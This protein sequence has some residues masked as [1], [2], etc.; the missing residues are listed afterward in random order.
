MSK[1][2]STMQAVI[3]TGHGGPEMLEVKQ[4]WSV[5][6]PAADEV[7]IKVGAAG[8]NNTDI[9]TRIGWYSKSVTADTDAAASS[10]G[11]IEVDTSDSSWAGASIQFPRIQGADVCG[12]IVAVGTGVSSNRIGERVL[13][14]AM[15]PQPDSKAGLNC[16][17]LGSEMDGGFAEY[18]TV[19]SDMT[20]SIMSSD[21]T[22]AELASFPCAAS[23]AENMLDRIG[24]KAGETVLITGASGGVGSA[25]VQLAKL[26]G[27]MVTA[28]AATEKHDFVRSLGA[29]YL[30]DRGDTLE[31][32]SY[33]AVVDLVV[34]P[35][36]NELIHALK[37]GGRYI[38]AGAI[39]GPIAEL[40]LRT[41]YLRDLTIAGSTFQPPR[42]FAN[43][44]AAIDTGALKPVVSKTY[45]LSQIGAAQADFVAKKYPG[46]LVLV[47][48]RLMAQ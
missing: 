2:P 10:A 41:V 17:T 19:K 22:D 48:D 11:D 23:T 16:I 30:I 34:G 21:L 5:P 35:Q 18:V 24:L 42:I 3:L 12:T 27:A 37:R 47:P 40:D 9:N 45:P 28:I 15:Q 38:T 4:D 39:A 33:D 43:L 36:W 31:Q 46:K 26:R 29:D 32:L 6:T 8:V 14:V 25:A 13:C 44:V 20:H 7:L 1:I